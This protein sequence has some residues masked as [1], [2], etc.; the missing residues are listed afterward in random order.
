MTS[1]KISNK[2][3]RFGWGI[4]LVALHIFSDIQL[5]Y[6]RLGELDIEV[7]IRITNRYVL[8]IAIK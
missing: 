1:G 7:F 5:L 8:V 4:L 2:I 6:E 3:P